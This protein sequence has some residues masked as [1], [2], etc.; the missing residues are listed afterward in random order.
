MKRMILLGSAVL[1]VMAISWACRTV[2]KAVESVGDATGIK[3]LSDLGKVIESGEELSPSEQYYVG[4]SVSANILVRYKVE[5]K[6]KELDHYTQ[7]VGEV[8][9]GLNPEIEG[10]FKGYRFTVLDSPQ[11]Q[12]VSAPAGF[13]F[14]ARGSIERAE[15]E[16]EVAAILAHEIAHVQLK[17]AL[18]AINKSRWKELGAS[19]ADLATKSS[20]KIVQ[21]FGGAV[22]D[23][24]VSLLD[25]GYDRDWEY[26][27]D[28]MAV[29]ILKTAGY[30]EEALTVYLSRLGQEGGNGGWFQTH[31]APADRIAELK[32]PTQYR[33]DPAL[34]IRTARFHSIRGS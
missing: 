21:G 3:P 33:P 18:R 28:A 31:P 5:E 26:A 16:D 2:G 24:G 6:K 34:D 9:I 11:V 13:V 30:H 22:G 27:A 12:A 25:K 10:T 15:T 20:S 4:R 7:L 8:L 32:L 17:H 14:V 29:Q 19:T 1:A 23:I